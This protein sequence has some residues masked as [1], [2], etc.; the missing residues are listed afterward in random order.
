M[1]KSL[2]FFLLSVGVL[3]TVTSVMYLGVRLNTERAISS[4]V[5]VVLDETLKEKEQLQTYST[6]I[7]EQLREKENRLAEL[8]DV[9]SIRTSLANAQARV[10]QLT[11]DLD[12]INRERIA[13]Q[14]ENLSLRSR[15]DSTT[16]EFMRSLE[17]L[18]QVK[19]E[20]ARLNSGGIAQIK[21]KS[22]ELSAATVAKDQELSQLK[23]E[24]EQL[25]QEKSALDQ[26]NK[27]LEKK[28]SQLQG[29]YAQNPALAQGQD[30]S[31]KEFQNTIKEL[32]TTLSA[33]ER[34]I[35]A[36]E[37][38]I[39]RLQAQQKTRAG[40]DTGEKLDQKL[41]VLQQELNA[42]QA[43]NARL[44]S[45]PRQGNEYEKLYQAAREQSNKLTELLVRKENEL[46]QARKDVLDSRERLVS[47]Q[48]KQSM[49][50][51]DAAS[52]RT[53]ESRLRELQQQNISL[54]N[55]INDLQANLS[56]KTEVADSLQRNLD[57]VT[58]Q[59]AQ[60]QEQLKVAET[61]MARVQSS[62]S[63]ELEK[64]RSRSQETGILYSS[65]K[66]QVA[67]FSDVL[68]QKEMEL[69]QKRREVR[70]LQDEINSLRSRSDTIERDLQ[71]AKERQKRTLDDLVAAVKLN[72]VLQERLVNMS[73]GGRPADMSTDQQKAD[74]L[75]RR[76]Q[77]ILESE[78]QK[79]P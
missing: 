73:L 41:A 31:L 63:Q 78:Q 66:T 3:S 65:L 52:S 35:V 10:E 30:V 71:E 24:L 34:Q 77:V 76:V 36:L 59:L 69:D 23:R 68:N 43:E 15:A 53:N 27:A 54:Q 75:R 55:Q 16:K 42:L 11:A 13:L 51:A 38:D 2:K 61:Q 67:Q 25:K 46:E 6:Q 5:N 9:E 74:E 57:Y 33:K 56:K 22:E 44:R 20:L 72:N 26:S 70:S 39:E 21:K 32:K 64:E 37:L 4:Q 18:K 48:T 60:S 45:A 62:I 79:K 49:L 19:A 8:R 1:T 47:L 7:E 12:K 17:E 58:K 50:E 14:S 29:Q 28:V 40:R